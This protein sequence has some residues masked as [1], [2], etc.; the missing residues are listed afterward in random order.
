MND[1]LLTFGALTQKKICNNPVQ[2]I[3]KEFKIIQSVAQSIQL[4]RLWYE[5]KEKYDRDSIINKVDE[6]FLTKYVKE[7]SSSKNTRPRTFIHRIL[8]PFR[9]RGQNRLQGTLFDIIQPPTGQVKIN[10]EQ[11]Y[12]PTDW[13][14][15]LIRRADRDHLTLKIILF[16]NVKKSPNI[17]TWKRKNLMFDIR[18]RDSLYERYKILSTQ[19]R[20]Q[21]KKSNYS[22]TINDSKNKNQNNNNANYNTSGKYNIK[23]LMEPPKK[24]NRKIQTL[25]QIFQQSMSVFYSKYIESL[26]K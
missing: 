13:R 3:I 24:A 20:I 4:L 19:P 25:A 7:A 14:I 5:N 6:L 9:K 17:E 26:S 12:K 16:C 1:S 15:P 8:Q 2:Q 18:S 11:L 10:Q 23:Q 21:P 22:Y